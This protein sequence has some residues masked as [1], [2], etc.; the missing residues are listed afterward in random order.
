MKKAAR[1][2]TIKK[3]NFAQKTLDIARVRGC[4]MREVFSYDLL[5]THFLL[6]GDGLMT[7]P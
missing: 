7:K 5:P 3:V 4:N 1:K 6:D 2:K